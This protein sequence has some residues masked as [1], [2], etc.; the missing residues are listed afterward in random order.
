MTTFTTSRELAANR[1]AVFAAIKDP[2]RL[3]TWWG[4]NGFSNRFDVFEFKPGGK[5][6]F[7]MIGP[8]GKTYANESVFTSI[9]TD[10]RVVIQHIS[11]PQFQLTITLEK[12][13]NGTRVIWEQAFADAAVANA[14]RHIVEPANEQNLDRLSAEVQHSN[15]TGA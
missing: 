10:A 8:D 13:S 4:P 2:A 9:E 5:W 12:S 11:P 14:V 1:T 7:A 15:G 6:V 3:A